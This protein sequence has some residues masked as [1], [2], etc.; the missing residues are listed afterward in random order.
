MSII[1][2]PSQQVFSIYETSD[3]VLMPC[4]RL[5]FCEEI[6]IVAFSF[7]PDDVEDF[8]AH[9]VSDPVVAHVDGL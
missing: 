1:N 3:E 5:K 7:S 9:T 4:R 6:S 8:L 2:T